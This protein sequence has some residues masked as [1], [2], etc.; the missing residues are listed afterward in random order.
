MSSSLPIRWLLFYTLCL[1]KISYLV[2]FGFNKWTTSQRYV[3]E[4][5]EWN[6]LPI[7]SY[8]TAKLLIWIKIEQFRRP[9]LGNCPVLAKEWALNIV[10]LI[11]Y[12]FTFVGGNCPMFSTIGNE[13][14]ISYIL[15]CSKLNNTQW[16]E[17]GAYISM[18]KVKQF[19][20]DFVPVSSTSNKFAGLC[21]LFGICYLPLINKQLPRGFAN[22]FA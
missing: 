15:V 3:C 11:C 4:A 5:K 1:C 20:K 9:L 14:N 18:F 22:F 6:G 8:V 12:L 21:I 2:L 13:N 16:K 7:Q 19:R 10:E 17:H